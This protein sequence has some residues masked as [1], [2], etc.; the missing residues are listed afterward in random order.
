MD[1]E[2]AAYASPMNSK[3]KEMGTQ[4]EN[5][6]EP[7]LEKIKKLEMEVEFLRREKEELKATICARRFSV[8]CLNDSDIKFYTSLYSMQLFMW[9][10]KLIYDGL[11]PIK[12]V[13]KED[14]VL[15]TLMKIRLGLLHKDI[16]LR[17]GI[18]L[19]TVSRIIS[20][21]IPLLASRLKFLIRW[22]S[23]DQIQRTLPKCFRK[24]YQNCRV[25]IDCSELF[26]ERPLNLTTRAQTFSSYK[27]HNTVKFLVGITP[28]GAVSFISECWGGRISDKE[29]TERSG[30]YNLLEAGDM[31]MAD[32]GFTI[33]NE[34]SFHG[35]QL[36]IPPFTRGKKQLPGQV[37]ES[38][39]RLSSARIH[40]ERT[41]ERIKNFRILKCT[42]TP[43]L[44]QASSDIVCICACLVNLQKKII[45]K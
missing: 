35:A 24:H 37:I 23:K 45:S 16:A 12:S 13:S 28:Y 27:Q 6:D 40:V 20:R 4:T 26:I 22:P 14:Q 39:R 44:A 11:I 42:L 17:F 36:V 1:D 2:G 21:T 19:S 18:S 33:A 15:I 5:T 8:K 41:I 32:R 38:A 3:F 43:S 29:L 25:I 34:I 9:V 7:Y 30:F 10:V 31:V